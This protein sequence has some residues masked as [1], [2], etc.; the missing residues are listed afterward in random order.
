MTKGTAGQLK[1]V[2]TKYN[3]TAVH[4]IPI[5]TVFHHLPPTTQAFRHEQNPTSDPSPPSSAKP[6]ARL[7]GLVSPPAT[8]H[9][10]FDA[11]H[12]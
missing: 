12:T 8:V 10:R 1:Y 5:N 4:I 7:S 2:H 11:F 6:V 3:E 9:E